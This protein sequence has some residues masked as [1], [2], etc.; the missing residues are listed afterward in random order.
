MPQTDTPVFLGVKLDTR[1]IEK[2]ERSS[3]QKLALMRKL[4]ITT[5][6]ADSSVLTKLYT[7]TARPANEYASANRGTAAKT[8]KNRLYK[9]QNMALRVI[10]GAMKTTPVHD[11]QKTAKVE[12]L[13][14]RGLISSSKEKY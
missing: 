12:P 2:I 4:A 8:N 13:E 3:L 7:A 9:V 11:M 5:W 6:V 1:L 14:R 10:L